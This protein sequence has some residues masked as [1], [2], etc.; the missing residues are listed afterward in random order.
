[1]GAENERKKLRRSFRRSTRGIRRCRREI[2]LLKLQRAVDERPELALEMIAETL[3][4]RGF[5]PWRGH[6]RS[7][8]PEPETESAGRPDADRQT[9]IE[10][11]NA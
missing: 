9:A 2:K 3:A 6:R 11:R 10:A 4:Q 7:Y 1:M 8:Y 5:L